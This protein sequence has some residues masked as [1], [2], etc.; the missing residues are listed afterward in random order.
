MPV[1]PYDIC[2]TSVRSYVSLLKFLER[3]TERGFHPI[4]CATVPQS[5]EE[6][7]YEERENRV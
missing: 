4:L 3:K 7:K 2:A 6:N 1:V 5:G